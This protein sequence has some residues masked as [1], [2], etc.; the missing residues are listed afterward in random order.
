MPFLV[1]GISQLRYKENRYG[2]FPAISDACLARRFLPKL[3]LHSCGP[4]FCLIAETAWPCKDNLA[5]LEF[6]AILRESAA[7]VLRQS[8]AYCSG[9]RSKMAIARMI[10]TE[11]D[12]RAG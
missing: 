1:D 5:Q 11:H 6:D 9:Q 8:F 10:E 12:H 3:G 7:Q 2:I 4:F